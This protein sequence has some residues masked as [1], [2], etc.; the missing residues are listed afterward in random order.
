MVQDP[1]MLIALRQCTHGYQFILCPVWVIV[2]K[3]L[4][5]IRPAVFWGFDIEADHQVD[6]RRRPRHMF[7]KFP[8]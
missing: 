6:G 1:Q 2:R 7:R 4:G 3:R 8:H 5:A